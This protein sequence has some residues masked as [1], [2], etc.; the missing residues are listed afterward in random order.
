MYF[1]ILSDL[2]WRKWIM[3]LDLEKKQ[4]L[5]LAFGFRVG[6]GVDLRLETVKR[7]FGGKMSFSNL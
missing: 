5:I 1:N 7:H 4:D 6:E 2:F 3:T